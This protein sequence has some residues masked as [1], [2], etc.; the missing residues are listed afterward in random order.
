MS[1]AVLELRSI[2]V[3]FDT[4]H[5]DAS[6]V[7]DVS[8]DLVSGEMLGIVGESG[9][10]KT[11]LALAILRLLPLTARV[12]GEVLYQGRDLLKEP[13]K[14]LRA[15]LGAEISFIPSSGK[16]ALVPVF[17]V[18]RQ[19]TDVIR[20]HQRISSE[21]A[22]D[23]AVAMLSRVGLSDPERRLASYPHELSGGMAQRVAIAMALVNHP[24]IVIA[25][26]PTG[27][28]DVTIQTQILDLMRELNATLGH[29]TILISRDLGVIANYCARVAVMYRGRLV[30]LGPLGQV[31]AQPGH[32][33][34]EA[35][36]D[37]F[38]LQRVEESRH[39]V[40]SALIDPPEHGCPYQP[41]CA[42]AKERCVTEDPGASALSDVHWARCHFARSFRGGAPRR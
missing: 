2:S 1:E 17:A 4:A 12:T 24:R 29:S 8:L 20:T 6:I 39:A 9:V 14:S 35:L 34:T 10:G 16:A 38:S 30:E 3:S 5:G 21:E 26:E 15:V 19:L 25:D 11:T 31:Y 40:A 41:R 27:G 18:G 22:R 33:Y 7:E 37:A 23:K 42:Y 13:E 32:P 36:L 28:L